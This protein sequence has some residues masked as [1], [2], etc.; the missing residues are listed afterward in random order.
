MPGIDPRGYAERNG[1]LPLAFGDVTPQWLTSVLQ[2]Q[3]PGAVINGFTLLARIPGHTTKARYLLE[4]NQMAIDAGIPAQVCLK[5]NW[6][7]DPLSSEVCVN[8]ARFFRLLRNTLE[9]PAPVCFIADWDDDATGK[10]GLIMLEDLIPQGGQFG[11]S[12]QSLSVDEVAASLEQLARL[13][14]NT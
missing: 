12:G 9:L 3:Y 13:H 7:G 2:N 14:A 8:E 4:R 6:T 11:T 10:Q 5:A 1:R